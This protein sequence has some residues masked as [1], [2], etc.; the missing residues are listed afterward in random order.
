MPKG[1]TDENLSDKSVR[2]WF[3]KN[4]RRIERA[5]LKAHELEYMDLTRRENQILNQARKNRAPSKDFRHPEEAYKDFENKKMYG[6][7]SDS[8]TFSD[9]SDG[10]A[11]VGRKKGFKENPEVYVLGATL[12]LVIWSLVLAFLL[13]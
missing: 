5:D 1:L 2:P 13:L 4:H 12:F 6:E 10:T 3:F 11:D 9:S 8:K 7:G